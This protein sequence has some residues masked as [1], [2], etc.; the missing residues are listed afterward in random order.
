MCW[1]IYNRRE[2]GISVC[3]ISLHRLDSILHAMGLTETRMRVAVCFI[4]Q[5]YSEIW[6]LQAYKQSVMLYN[7]LSL[8]LY[9]AFKKKFIL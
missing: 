8:R 4:F 9:V 1:S 6:N 7:H 3:D 5:S 2:S